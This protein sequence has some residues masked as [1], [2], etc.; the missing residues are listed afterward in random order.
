MGK[1]TTP[2]NER[3]LRLCV[4]VEQHE[5][6]LL[7]LCCIYLRDAALAEDAV[8]E[9]F[10]KAYRHLDGFQAR[11]AVKTWLTRIAINVCK[12]I[13]KNAWYRYVDFRVSLDR[14]PLPVSP[15]SAEHIALT[16]EIMR[17][18]RPYMEAVLLHYDQGF[19]VTETAEILGLT[20]AAVS[21]RLKKARQ[22][23]RAALE[24]GEED[25]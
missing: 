3:A 15:P 2:D 11:S 23:L 8:Q 24:G 22:K 4:L 16:S 18:K 25:V 6:A 7:R 5:K 21:V 13:R 12:D 1:D 9:T 10:L 20:P 19:S 14:L 17:L